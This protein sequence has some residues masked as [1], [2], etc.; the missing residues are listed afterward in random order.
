VKRALF[1]AVGF[2]LL[3]L[4]KNALAVYA[5]PSDRRIAWSTGLD[6]EGGI[7]NYTPVACSSAVGD[8]TTEAGA[9]IQSCINSA[10][11]GTAVYLREGTFKVSRTLSMKT[12]IS[13]RGAGPTQTRIK[14]YSGARISFS[15]GSKTNWGA[16]I[17]ITSG[18]TKGSTSLVL[19]TVSGLKVGDW[20]SISRKYA[21]TSI[22]MTAGG[23]KWCGDDSGT[24]SYLMQQYAKI[25]AISGNT[26]TI[27]RPMYYDFTLTSGL[28][29][30]VRKQPFNI[31]KAG[32]ED[33]QVE[34]TTTTGYMVYGMMARHCW[35]KNIE[36][37]NSGARSG[38]AH[39]RLEFSHGWEIR[40]SYFHHGHGY[41]SGQSYGLLMIF[42]NSDHKIENNIY[43]SIRHV[44]F[45]GGGSGCAV[46]YNYFDAN[47]ESEDY[48]FLNA[49]LN[50][51]HGAHPHMNLMEGNSSAKITW[52]RTWG[53]SSHSTAFRN[54]ARGD[55]SAP[56]YEWGIWAI[57][58][59]GNNRYM[60]IVGNVFG[61][62]G[63]S[64]GT[65]L[66][67]G[68]CPSGGTKTALRFGCSGQPGSYADAASYSTAIVHGNY[69]YITDGVASWADPDHALPDS[70]YYSS[71]PSWWGTE[72]PWPAIGP[73]IAGIVADIPAKR[74]FN[75]MS[76]L[77][78][79]PPP[80]D[81]TV[82]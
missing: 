59:Q 69:D 47:R 50:P 79:P 38:D 27:N 60:N 2:C 58:V 11:P 5:L 46:L 67:N 61:M 43:Y 63:W 55:R 3:L 4:T 7:P 68:S 39:V 18:Y 36:S 78:T 45:E 37:Y 56:P 62:S 49:D 25:T 19:A 51:N 75:G 77:K 10:S 82:R 70:L 33:L 52:D 44:A 29:P 28:Q 72:T 54:H 20:V 48:T 35:L 30:E 76:G 13:L 31:S 24:G 32:L 34:L 73:D 65:V 23:C 17:G 15:G 21:D 40:D 8:G 53:S 71:V 80:G 81:V 9:S 14:L 42:W 26:I 6:S 22:G 66:S 74:R 1:V 16:P 12:G 64:T 41:G 57:D